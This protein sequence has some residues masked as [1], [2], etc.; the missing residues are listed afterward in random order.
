[1]NFLNLTKLSFVGSLQRY[2]LA[3]V[4]FS[5][6][7]FVNAQ[8][9]LPNDQKLLFIGQDVA[10]VEGYRANCTGCH[11]GHGEIAYLSFYTLEETNL[12][13]GPGRVIY[14][15][16]IGMDNNGNRDT[17]NTRWGAGPLN[18]WSAA[19]RYPLVAIGLSIVEDAYFGQDGLNQIINGAHDSKIVKMATFFNQFPS[20]VFYLRIGYEFDGNWNR[21]EPTKYVSAYKRI[22]DILNANLSQDNVEYVWQ[23][24]T[25]PVDDILDGDKEDITKYYPGKEYVDWMG[26]SWFLRANENPTQAPIPATQLELA[27]ELVAFAKLEGKPV[28]VAES[29]P[30]GYQIDDKT[31][32]NISP[33][34]DGAA[35]Q[36][37]ANKTA[38]VLYEEWFGEL[39]DFVAANDE[40]RALCYINADWDSQFLWSAANNYQIG[41]WGDTRVEADAEVMNLWKGS[42][43][44]PANK[45]LQSEEP[46]DIL[47]I[48][49]VDDVA[50]NDATNFSVYPNPVRNV[51]TVKGGVDVDTMPYQLF[52]I[53]GKKVLEGISTDG[54]PIN[55]SGLTKGVYMLKLGKSVAVKKIVKQ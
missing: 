31:N 40:V 55:V 15:G 39:F 34:Y 27:N 22:V 25:S 38:T 50:T 32:C 47:N 21:Y 37:C 23:S 14:Y 49:S 30:Q 5:S 42:I 53:D 54:A 16:G 43:A 35:A 20:N 46:S 26:L 33:G 17:N 4:A 13:A 8:R 28:M 19:E 24:S 1:M 7:Q 41:Y 11:K 12:D 9:Y 48:L 52:A 2:A 3:I 10:S 29:S 51:L 45:F 44:D 6:F 36:G 18:L